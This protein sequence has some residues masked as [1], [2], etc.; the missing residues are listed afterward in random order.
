M[1]ISLR[2]DGPDVGQSIQIELCA[3]EVRHNYCTR[4]G[5]K[6]LNIALVQLRIVHTVIIVHAIGNSKLKNTALRHRVPD[7]LRPLRP[8][9]RVVQRGVIRSLEFNYEEKV[10]GAEKLIGERVTS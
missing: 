6:Y 3:T 10:R 5:K 1:T 8:I 9:R 7:H 4:C 2:G